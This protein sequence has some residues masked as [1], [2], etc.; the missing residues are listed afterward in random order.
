MINIFNFMKRRFILLSLISLTILIAAC[1]GSSP[2]GNPKDTLQTF[3]EL[4]SKKDI[5]N[6]RKYATAD[7]K[8]LLNLME[9]AFKMDADPEKTKQFDKKN[10]ELGEGTINGETATVPVKD[11]TS[12]ESVDFTLRK[13][14]GAWKV[15]FDMGTL[16]QIGMQKMKEKNPAQAD[17]LIKKMSAMKNVNLDSLQ[18]L[19]KNNVQSLDSIKKLM[20][21]KGD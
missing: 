18:D 12:G 2:A 7:S 5:E 16:M 21:Q 14:G 20:K 13:E 4:L 8:N 10:M 17:S 19:L 11:V 6:A 15:A 9:T 3:F 1:N